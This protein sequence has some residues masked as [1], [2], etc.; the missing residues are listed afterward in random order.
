MLVLEDQ[1]ALSVD[2]VAWSDL[3][4]VCQ[5]ESGSVCLLCW[6]VVLVHP[7]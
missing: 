3:R 6:A 1:V 7:S 4:N 5:V 2:L